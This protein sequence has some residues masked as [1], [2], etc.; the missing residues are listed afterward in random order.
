MPAEVV[1]VQHLFHSHEAL[2]LVTKIGPLWG[3]RIWISERRPKVT[4]CSA[5]F[6]EA[7]V[8]HHFDS[9]SPP[10]GTTEYTISSASLPIV[11]EY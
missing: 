9:D 6:E 11:D 1:Q 5:A 4:Y 3:D 2:M 7:S 10:Y 8:R